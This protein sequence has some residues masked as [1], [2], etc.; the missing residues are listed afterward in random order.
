MGDIT[1]RSRSTGVLKATLP[2]VRQAALHES[3]SGEKTFSF[4]VKR[5]DVPTVIVGD[6]VTYAGESYDV[7]RLGVQTQTPDALADVSCEHVSY[8]L[9]TKTVTAGTYTGT[10]S[11]LLA[12]FLSGTGFTAGTVQ[13]TSSVTLIF[14][15]DTN[16][17][18]AL[19]GLSALSHGDLQYSGTTVSLLN[20]LGSSVPVELS[21]KTNVESISVVIDDR[22]GSMS[23][24]VTLYKETAMNVGDVVHVDYV[25][26]GLSDTA[27]VISRD[28][29]PFNPLHLQIITG[30]YV[31]NF[32]NATADGWEDVE[33]ALTETIP[34]KVDE[35]LEIT[36]VRAQLMNFREWDSGAWSE[37]L[38]NGEIIDYEVTFD[39]SGRPVKITDGLH[40]CDIY[41]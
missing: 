34:E 3:L 12:G 10:P 29:D 36:L 13:P 22:S 7:V 30:D 18:A 6:V 40:E 31:P 38:D 17:R 39:S 21:D 41:W 5:A 19:V 28:V 26:L 25:T 33:E 24:N 32:V 11:Q 16:V 20:H 4:R 8:R 27:R 15:S 2:R 9:L 14:G 23:I 35:A 1:I 37:T